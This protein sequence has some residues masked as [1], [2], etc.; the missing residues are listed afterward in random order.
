MLRPAICQ[1]MEKA[2]LPWFFAKAVHRWSKRVSG[3]LIGAN[4]RA[5]HRVAPV[6]MSLPL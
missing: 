2:A 6:L 5:H 3:G 1:A 4:S